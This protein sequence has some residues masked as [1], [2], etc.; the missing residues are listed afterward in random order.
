MNKVDSKDLQIPENA[1]ILFGEPL[2]DWSVDDMRMWI[3]QNTGE[4]D[5]AKAIS[6][7]KM[8]SGWLC[9]LTDDDGGE[10]Y[11]E[12]AHKWWELEKELYSKVL[13]I[14]EKE[15]ELGIANH[16]LSKAGLHFRIE[17]FMVRNGYRDGAGWW[18]KDK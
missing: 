14:L 4:S 15:N 1:V 3:S 11:S 13:S 8:K 2:K 12:E 16:D 10:I 17:P 7:V 9:H 18:V 5:I 6:L